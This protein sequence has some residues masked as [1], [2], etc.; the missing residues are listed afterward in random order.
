MTFTFIQVIKRVIAVAIA[1]ATVIAVIFI[2]VI[3]IIVILVFITFNFI[4]IIITFTFLGILFSIIIIILILLSVVFFWQKYFQSLRLLRQVVN[5]LISCIEKNNKKRRGKLKYK[6]TTESGILNAT[7]SSLCFSFFFGLDAS[8]FFGVDF[9][10][11]TFGE[12]FVLGEMFLACLALPL[13]H[14]HSR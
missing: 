10:G 8:S 9:L 13:L 1:V 6:P 5:L 14:L 4:N 3:V 7:L 12:T 11:T 2:V